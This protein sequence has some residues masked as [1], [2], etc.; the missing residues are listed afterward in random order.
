MGQSTEIIPPVT[1]PPIV[2]GQPI[3]G[4]DDA[5]RRLPP[6]GYSIKLIRTGWDLNDDFTKEI[7][8]L[9][10]LR[11]KLT[12]T[13]DII[14]KEGQL[15]PLTERLAKLWQ[16]DLAL[17]HQWSFRQDK[18][19]SVTFESEGK[20]LFLPTENPWQ[21]LYREPEYLR[22]I[23]TWLTPQPGKTGLALVGITAQQ[24]NGG[25]NDLTPSHVGLVTE[26]EM[27][28]LVNDLALINNA[29]GFIGD[30]YRHGILES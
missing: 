4:F 13:I 25:K 28:E 29:P 16:K 30:A 15:P 23:V 3:S 7:L 20:N 22:L 5:L 10:D 9:T 17:M 11:I 1:L 26:N 18:K 24:E 19:R 21:D 27:G 8:S 2:F 12:E 14:K 6:R